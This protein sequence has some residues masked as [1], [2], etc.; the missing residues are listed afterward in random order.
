M[1]ST[2]RWIRLVIGLWTASFAV[3]RPAAAQTEAAAKPWYERGKL[4]GLVYAD[5]AYFVQSHDPTFDGK[6][7]FWLRRIYFTYDQDLV[8]PWSFRVRLEANSPGDF[9]SSATLTPFFKDAYLQWMH[10]A[11]RVQFGLLQT[12]SFDLQER[13]WGYRALEKTVMDLHRIAGPRDI[14]VSALAHITKSGKLRAFGLIGNGANTGSETNQG[15]K[16]DLA[17][18][19]FPSEHWIAQVYG[20]YEE[21]VFANRET[22]AGFAAY[23]AP[24]G[25]VGVEYCWQNRETQTGEDDLRFGSL[26]GSFKLKPRLNAVGRVDRGFDPNPEGDKIPFLP[27][28]TKS[29]FW[30][31]LAGFEWVATKQVSITPNVEFVIYDERDDGSQADDDVVPRLTMDFRF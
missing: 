4:S 28:D 21:K 3:L 19:A 22:V 2:R 29:K 1:T 6:S 12:P 25:R 10:G 14:G 9:S 11:T 8:E 15:K 27:F 24:A 31:G 18:Q 23:T 16:Y 20:D 26:W 30:F 17:L 13:T 7:V 5:Y